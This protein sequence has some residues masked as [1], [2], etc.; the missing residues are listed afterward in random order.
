ML[1]NQTAQTSDQSTVLAIRNPSPLL[2]RQY[3]KGKVA[4]VGPSTLP[5]EYPAC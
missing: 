3:K 4:V 2:I 1:V 5:D